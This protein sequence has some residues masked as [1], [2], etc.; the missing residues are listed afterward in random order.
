MTI[1]VNNQQVEAYDLLLQKKYAL[2]IVLGK[3]KIEVRSFSDHYIS[4]FLDKEVMK[5]NDANNRKPFD[6][7]YENEIR[8]DVH[9]IHFHNYNN[10]W[11]LDVEIEGIGMCV[12]DS[13]DIEPLAADFPEMAAYLPDARKNDELPEE[14]KPMIF[15][16]VLAD[17]VDHNLK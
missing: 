10:S 15:Y 14:D 6:D 17:V 1:T 7:D 3:K 9:Y 8:E 12:V 5:R 13:Q 11:Y 2:D 16:I 4:R